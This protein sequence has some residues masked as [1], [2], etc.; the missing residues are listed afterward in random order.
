[1][2]WLD[3]HSA[4]AFVSVLS[5][6]EI[7]KGIGLL[8][9]ERR[10]PLELFIESLEEEY[11]DRVLSADCEVTK[12]WGQY[13]A[14]QERLGRKLPVVDSLLAATALV[15]DL[16]LATRN[17]ADFPGVRTVNPWGK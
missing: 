15:H 7:W 13:L 8:P 16:T 17:T 14:E 5:L 6:G 4:A 11:A 10:E 3:Q 1:M 9:S 12:R 2:H